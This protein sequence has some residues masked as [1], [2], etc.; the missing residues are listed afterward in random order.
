MKKSKRK[1]GNLNYNIIFLLT[2]LDT[3]PRER[4]T[5]EDPRDNKVC[6]VNS[7]TK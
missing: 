6:N 3:V 4:E 2:F 1:N 5:K 7:E